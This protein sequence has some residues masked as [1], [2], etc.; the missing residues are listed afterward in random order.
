MLQWLLAGVARSS[1]DAALVGAAAELASRWVSGA[2]GAL[3]DVVERSYE[4]ERGRWLRS[5]QASRTAEID[6]I[7]SGRETDAGGA[8]RRL[9]Y[10]LSRHHIAVL[11][12]TTNAPDGVDASSQLDT[13]VSEIAEALG[14]EGT[15]TQPLG[16]LDLA[17]GLSRGREFAPAALARAGLSQ[18]VDRDVRVAIGDP[19]VG[20]G[21]FRRS[22]HQA[23]AAR[24]IAISAPRSHGRVTRY[25]R[26]A[27]VAAL[28]ADEE[29]ARMFVRR[30]LGP[31]TEDD[32]A[33]RRIAATL[34]VFLEEHASRAR[35][36][37][38]LGIHENTVTY[39]VRQAEEIL[40]RP[41]EDHGLRL[42]AA[43]MLLPTVREQP[44]WKARS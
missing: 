26:V 41:I 8:S 18:A 6:E 34:Q 13:A 4:A 17:A 40:G 14:A 20:L 5:M 37:K 12:W 10:E 43:L 30:T 21:G 39:R 36:A 19:G 22:H 2:F 23:Q 1:D 27:A 24:R 16:L 7:T 3:A 44:A 15:L 25:R 29:H 9:R 42:S 33:T 11:A 32:D 28:S 38:R 31:L 35:A